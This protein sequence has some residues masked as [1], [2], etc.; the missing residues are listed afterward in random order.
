MGVFSILVAAGIGMVGF[1]SM[2]RS[3]RNSRIEAV[4]NDIDVLEAKNLALEAQYQYYIDQEYL[5]NILTNIGQMASD[6]HSLQSQTGQEYEDDIA[7]MSER[8]ETSQANY[9]EISELSAERGFRTEDGL[10]GQYID[11]S[12]AL[13]ESFTALVDKQEWLELKWAESVM[14]TGGETVTLDGTRYVK[15]KYRGPVPENVKRNNLLFRV[16]GTFDYNKDCYISDIQLTG[17]AGSAQ[18]D[19]E[20]VDKAQGSGLAYVDSEIVTFDSKPAIRVGCNFNAANACWEEFS[21]QVPAENY[22]AQ[23]YANIEYTIYFEYTNGSYDYKYGGAY[24]G[25]Y[26]FAENLERLNQ[27]VEDYSKLVV[28]GKDVAESYAQSA[29]EFN[30]E[31][32]ARTVVLLKNKNGLLPLDKHAVHTIGVIGPNADSRS[33]LV[34]NYEGTASRYVTVLEGIQD[35]VGDDVRVL[36][37]QGCHLY[38]DKV[39]ILAQEN[40]REAEVKA[41]CE[42]SDVVIAV[43]GMDATL[44]GEEGDTGNEYGSGDKPN[45]ALPGLQHHILKKAAECGKPVILVCLTGSAISLTWEEEHLDAILQGW[46]PGAQGGAAIAR[47]LFGDD[48]P[49]GRLPVT[50]YRTMEELPAFEDYSMKG[51]TYRY[52]E[53]EALYPFGYGLS[54]TSF[55]YHDITAHGSPDSDAGVAVCFTVENTG[56]R[57]GTETVQAYVKA[58]KPGTPNAQ[59]KGILKVFLKAGERRQCEICLPREAFLLCD[60]S[61][62]RVMPGCG[63]EIS[64]GGSQPD[65][66]SEQLTGCAVSRID[67]G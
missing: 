3:S 11:A 35:Y 44:E 10:Y 41:V 25:V 53:Q 43:M 15:M 16:G 57:D 20:A 64:I 60:E 36:Y 18:I 30:R 33:A 7:K 40:D 39:N 37:S 6:V 50:F 67:I 48:N 62:A 34:G 47:V 61:G 22:E 66:R 5:S 28:E 2:D 42:A 45:L 58:K 17:G 4:V 23:N 32:S 12:A 1:Y 51:R 13:S 26:R 38:K 54:Y 49:Q 56:D 52:M 9:S 19:L 14:W 63:Y 21:V 8:L 46:Y 27:Y 24:S 31:V 65:A 29:R 59:L 55:A